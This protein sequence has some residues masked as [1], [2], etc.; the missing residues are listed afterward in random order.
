[1][2][3]FV[4][5]TAAEFR[6]TTKRKLG[7]KL[8]GAQNFVLRFQATEEKWFMGTVAPHPVCFIVLCQSGNAGPGVPESSSEL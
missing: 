1:M 4:Q 6:K 8:L 2:K 5:H 7:S 3:Q